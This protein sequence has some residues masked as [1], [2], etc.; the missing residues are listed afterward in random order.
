MVILSVWICFGY[1]RNLCLNI[2]IVSEFLLL[3]YLLFVKCYVVGFL[4]GWFVYLIKRIR[5]F[6]GLLWVI[7]EL[8]NKLLMDLNV[9]KFYEV[10]VGFLKMV[11]FCILGMLY[12][13]FFYLLFFFCVWIDERL[14]LFE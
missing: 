9:L 11:L 6:Y 10:G 4:E 13:W 1:Y 14:I 3:K 12:L 5:Y 7:K 8:V 2:V